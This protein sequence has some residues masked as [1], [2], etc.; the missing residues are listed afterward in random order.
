MDKN[1][2]DITPNDLMEHQAWYFPMDDSVESEEIVRQMPNDRGP[3]DCRFILRTDFIDQSSR[4]FLGYLYWGKPALI[5]YLQPVL[6]LAPD[7]NKGL[8]FWNGMR[9]P[10]LSD[11]EQARGTLDAKSFPITYRTVRWP[12]TDVLEGVLEGI[13]FLDVTNKIQVARIP[14]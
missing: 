1:I 4:I 14:F 13:Y 2:N 9:P 10:K 5:E 8:A 6:F 12:Q 3:D 11:F 7:G